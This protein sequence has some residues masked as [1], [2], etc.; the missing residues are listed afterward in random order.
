MF[1]QNYGSHCENIKKSQHKQRV[2]DKI[3]AIIPTE[4]EKVSCNMNT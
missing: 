4:Y 2:R 1:N 3:Y